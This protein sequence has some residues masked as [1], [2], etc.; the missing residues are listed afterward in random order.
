MWFVGQ[1]HEPPSSWGQPD[2]DNVLLVQLRQQLEQYFSGDR[3]EF[4]LELAPQ[5]T[6][7]QLKVWEL[8]K[9]IPYGQ[10]VSYGSLACQL[11]GKNMARAVGCAV[12]RNP[13]SLLIP[14]HRV[15]GAN[16]ELTGYAGGLDRKSALLGLESGK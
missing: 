8:L 3:R 14:C 5:G 2:A 12:G 9:A 13:I 7:F 10:T 4:T 1:K 15:I 6:P 11:G 16:G